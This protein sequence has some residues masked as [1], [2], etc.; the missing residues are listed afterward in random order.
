MGHNHRA[1]TAL[2]EFKKKKKVGSHIKQIYQTENL[3]KL[4]FFPY[5]L[6]TARVIFPHPAFLKQFESQSLYRK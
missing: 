2:L 3:R 4:Y 6:S 5:T 1:L